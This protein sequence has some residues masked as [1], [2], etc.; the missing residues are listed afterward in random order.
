MAMFGLIILCVLVFCAIFADVISPYDYYEQDLSK[1]F[2][3]PNSE[4]WFGTD[5]FGRD[6][7]SRIIYGTRITLQIGIIAVGIAT[8]FGGF[9]GIISAYY[10]QL[11]NVIMRFMD[12]FLAIPNL[13]LAIALAAVLGSGL[14]NLMLAISITFMPRM[15]RVVRAAAITVKEQEYI[16][17]AVSIGAS[18]PRII[19]RHIIP[20]ALSPIIVQATIGVATSILAAAVLSYLGLGVKMPIPEWG[21]MLSAGKAYMRNHWHMTVIPGLA[22][23]I[24]VFSLNVLGDGLRDALDPRLKD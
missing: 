23:M 22:I 19:F 11:D 13:L 3:R 16:E 10:R 2:Q 7:F 24:T 12:V 20:N 8:L 21:A 1:S 6:M 9:F 17:A 18:T 5:D 14:W 15:A 4:H